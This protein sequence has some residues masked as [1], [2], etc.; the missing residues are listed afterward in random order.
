VAEFENFGFSSTRGNGK[1]KNKLKKEG[2][3]R[4]KKEKKRLSRSP[5]RGII[6]VVVFLIPTRVEGYSIE[7]F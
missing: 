6:N 2:K 5:T 3:E 4:G 1:E 7:Y